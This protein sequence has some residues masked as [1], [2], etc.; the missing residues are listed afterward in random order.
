MCTTGSPKPMDWQ[1]EALHQVIVDLAEAKHWAWAR[2][3]SRS[4]WR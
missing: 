3:R 4:A 2:W 1:K